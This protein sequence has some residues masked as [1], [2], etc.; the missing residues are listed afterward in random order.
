MAHHSSYS[1]KR[2]RSEDVLSYIHGGDDIIVSMA[3]GEPNLL[4]DTI[5]EHAEQMK[6][7]NIH[8]MHAQRDRAYIRGKYKGR[9]EH[10]AY[11]LSG[12][13]RKAYNQGQCELVPNHFYE[14]PRIL[15]ERTNHKLV[16]MAKIRSI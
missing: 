13:S 14:V 9:L 5:E 10:I 11:Y 4:L 16:L 3:N 2:K 1:V 7:V 12:A 6:Q 8:Q 15:W